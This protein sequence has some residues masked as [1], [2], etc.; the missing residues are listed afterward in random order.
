MINNITGNEYSDEWYTDRE[1][2]E[3]MLKVFPCKKGAVVLCPFDS[4]KS[5]FVK[6]M[7]ELGHKVIYGINDFMHQDYEF[8]AIYTNPPF[9]IKTEVIDRC[10]STGKKSTLILPLDVMGGVKRHELYKKTKLIVFVPT[11]RTAFYDEFG[12]KRKGASF[13]SV[14]VQ[15]NAD[16]NEVIFE[17]E[18]KKGE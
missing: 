3:K 11:R 7:Q 14:F 18:L 5:Q 1:T 9:S 15:L 17:Y 8:D 2:V 10:I 16:K 6:V 4:V 12:N 13:H